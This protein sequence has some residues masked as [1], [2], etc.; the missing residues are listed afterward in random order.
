MKDFRLT[1]PESTVI[2]SGQCTYCLNDLTTTNSRRTA[3]DIATQKQIGEIMQRIN[4]GE[5]VEVDAT[6]PIGN[7]VV[8]KPCGHTF[9]A[10]CLEPAIQEWMQRRRQT[11]TTMASEFPPSFHCASCTVAVDTTVIP[12]PL[13]PTSTV[14]LQQAYSQGANISTALIDNRVTTWLITAAIGAKV[15]AYTLP[16]LFQWNRCDVV[17][18]LALIAAYT[19]GSLPQP[20]R[21]LDLRH[22][23]AFAFG[24]LVLGPAIRVGQDLTRAALFP[25]FET[26]RLQHVITLISYVGILSLS[27]GIA[28]VNQF[29]IRHIDHALRRIGHTR[30]YRALGGNLAVAL[31]RAHIAWRRFQGYPIP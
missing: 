14:L 18:A 1:L 4:A 5:R 24:I 22:L 12:A 29:A 30:P 9:H 25:S 26:N 23:H 16:V 28:K 15:C 2:H 11:L 7:V 8:L 13:P 21:N 17:S 10:R 6:K 20:I 3:E 19:I 27:Y 31:R